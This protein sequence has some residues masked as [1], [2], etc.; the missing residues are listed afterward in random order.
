MT[1][2]VLTHVS[3]EI[4]SRFWC[5]STRAENLLSGSQNL[6]NDNGP[7][8]YRIG[9]FYFHPDLYVCVCVEGGS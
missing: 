9:K 2:F 6:H 5:Q 4:C 3:S 8:F 7:E 1:P